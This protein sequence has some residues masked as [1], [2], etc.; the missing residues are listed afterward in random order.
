MT[1]PTSTAST[2]SLTKRAGR[3]AYRLLENM[4][5]SAYQGFQARERYRFAYI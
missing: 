2:P 1:R 5:E 3:L 4:T